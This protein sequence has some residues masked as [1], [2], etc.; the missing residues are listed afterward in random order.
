MSEEDY[1]LN[2]PGQVRSGGAGAGS[3][4]AAETETA[5]SK[6]NAKEL[7]VALKAKE[8]KDIDEINRRIDAGEAIEDDVA[9]SRNE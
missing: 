6:A 1:V 3:D 5:E 7:Q 2:K 9:E 4:A 8:A